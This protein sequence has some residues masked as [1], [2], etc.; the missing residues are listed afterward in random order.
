MVKSKNKHCVLTA[1]GASS[2][3]REWINEESTFDLHLIIYDD[4]YELFKT[5]SPYVFVN[6]GFKFKL[7]YKY[8]TENEKLMEQY[9]FFY[10]PDDDISIDYHNIQKLFDYMEKYELAVAQPAITNSFFSHKHTFRQENSILRYTNFVEIMQPCFSRDALKKVLFT[11][12]ESIS[13]WG[14]D[15]HWGILLNYAE[16]NMAII[17]DVISIHTRPVQS[18]HYPEMQEYMAKYNLSSDIFST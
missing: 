9:D 10:M 1:A 5:D 12:N 4:S 14:I 6:K 15:F 13:G 2:L 18:S 8:L 16:Y 17:D 11:F 7:F 3:H